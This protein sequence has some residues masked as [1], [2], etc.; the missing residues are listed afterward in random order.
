[1]TTSPE[2][3]VG[4]P[5][6]LY[7][8]LDNEY[9]HGR[10]VDWRKCTIY[11]R[12]T[13]SSYE[14]IEEHNVSDDGLTSQ[15]N[16]IST[17][18]TSAAVKSISI[19]QLDY[20][21]FGPLS[22]CEFL[23]R[24]PSGL[25]G[26]KKELLKWIMLE[27]HSLAVG[28]SLILG[29]K[30]KLSRSV[31]WKPA[32]ILARSALELVP[33]R[34][35]LHE[36]ERGYVFATMATERD[37]THA[38]DRWALAS[39]FG[40]EQH[41]LLRL[42]D[43]ACDFLDYPNLVRDSSSGNSTVKNQTAGCDPVRVEV[44]VNDVQ[45]LN[46]RDPLA[47]IDVPLALALAEHDEQN[48]CKVWNILLLRQRDHHLALVSSDTTQSRLE[49]VDKSKTDDTYLKAT[50]NTSVRPLV[51]RGLD[52]M[53]LAQL[54]ERT[55]PLPS[56]STSTKRSKDDLMIFKCEIVLSMSNAMASLQQRQ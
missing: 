46:Q 32:M 33:V 12:L 50:S 55:N 15:Q 6:R 26:R 24:F 21:G 1:V 19:N 25:Q 39:F 5:T 38:D 8:N 4:K 45:L 56:H 2:F 52:R 3:L 10:I 14:Y 53:W 43:E 49:K 16:N 27:E 9:H 36:D 23:V 41:D 34:S 13:S 29:K 18:N 28:V 48:R 35:F 42:R 31:D 22:T 17:N 40:D 11:P 51:E 30:S 20:Y 7:N 47:S 54:L 44:A 37:N